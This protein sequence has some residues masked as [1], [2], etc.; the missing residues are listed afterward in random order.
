MNALVSEKS[1][2]KAINV[3]LKMS[4]STVL[5]GIQSGN[6]GDFDRARSL[7]MEISCVRA[8]PL[9][10]FVRQGKAPGEILENV[11]GSLGHVTAL[12]GTLCVEFLC[13]K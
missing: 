13:W 7:C 8:R 1:I 9:S 5:H 3:V 12:L 10:F 4:F 11:A 2:L 6:A